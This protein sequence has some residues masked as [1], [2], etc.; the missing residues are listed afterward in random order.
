MQIPQH[1]AD[2]GTRVTQSGNYIQIHE[3]QSESGILIS[4]RNKHAEFLPRAEAQL[5]MEA[6]EIVAQMQRLERRLDR[7]NRGLEV[8]RL[9]M[10]AALLAKLAK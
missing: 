4:E 2:Y 9:E 7:I 10:D 5:M 6:G 3:K 8:V 1:L